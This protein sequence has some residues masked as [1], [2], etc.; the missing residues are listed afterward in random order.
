MKQTL[1]ISQISIPTTDGLRLAGT[2]YQRGDAADRAVIICGA[3]GIA[4]RHYDAYAKHL[5]EQGFTVVTFDYRGI[6]GSCVFH[7]IP[8]THF[9]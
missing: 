4:R 5:C 3:M 6:G 7:S 1:A 2:L 9:T 8:A